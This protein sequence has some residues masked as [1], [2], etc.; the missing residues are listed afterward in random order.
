MEQTDERITARRRYPDTPRVGVAAAVFNEAGEVLLVKRGRPPGAGTWGIPGGRLELGERLAEGARREVR[1]EC[2]VEIEVGAIISAFESITHDGA[3]RVEYHYVVVDY[4]AEY[5]SGEAA[6][7]DDAAAVAWVGPADLD[8]YPMPADTRAV[9]LQGRGMRGAAR[10]A[11]R[12]PGPGP[13][14]GSSGPRPP[15]PSSR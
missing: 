4:W 12:E 3:G 14:Q 13:G 2:G 8:K 15:A 7:Q 6:A 10:V 9:I 1:E 11:L 5:V